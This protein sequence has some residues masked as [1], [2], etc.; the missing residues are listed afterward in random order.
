MTA[1]LAVAI[2]ALE[3]VGRYRAGRWRGQSQDD[4]EDELFRIAVLDLS[5]PARR[6]SEP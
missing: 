1:A 2:G 5:L 3:I 6:T 4:L